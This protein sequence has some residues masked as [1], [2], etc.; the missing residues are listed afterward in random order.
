MRQ[1]KGNSAKIQNIYEKY[2]TPW[3]KRLLAPKDSDAMFQFFHSF[4]GVD[5][6]MVE[7]IEH[8]A[9][10]LSKQAKTI[11]DLVDNDQFAEAN[12]KIKKLRHELGPVRKVIA[13]IMKRLFDL[14]AQFIE[15]SGA[16]GA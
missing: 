1:A 6:E 12:H 16:V 11:A 14:E 7:K 5:L 8:T 13:E 10:W 9:E 3:F 4:H 15:D 2:L